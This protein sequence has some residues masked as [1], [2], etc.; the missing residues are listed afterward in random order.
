MNNGH[1]KNELTCHTC[2]HWHA[3]EATAATIGQ[4]KRGDCRQGPPHATSLPDGRGNLGVVSSYP[5]LP[6]NFPAC[7]QHAAR[8]AEIV[9]E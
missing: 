9:R 3:Q 5:L 2:K 1:G 7:G 4:I 6:A 8:L